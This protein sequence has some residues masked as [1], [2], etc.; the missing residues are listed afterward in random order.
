MKITTVEAF[1]N[2]INTLLPENI[3]KE[4]GHFNVFDTAALFEKLDGKM[5]MPYNRRAFYKISLIKGR[6]RAEYADKVI[7]IEN[8][9]L[10]FGTPKIPYHW[11]ALEDN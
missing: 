8:T 2:E 10:L 1:Y 5:I 3:S 7:H 9:A 11:E 4:I 6:N